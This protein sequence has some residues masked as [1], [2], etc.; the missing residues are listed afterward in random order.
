MDVP[1]DVLNNRLLSIIDAD[2]PKGL[3]F[4]KMGLVIYFYELSEIPGNKKYKN[5]ADSLLTDLIDKG[6]SIEDGLGIE[7]G[8]CGIGLGMDYLA[9]KKFISGD[10][11]FM[12]SDIDSSLFRHI[13]FPTLGKQDDVKDLS[14][15]LLYVC[16]RLRCQ[17]SSENRFLYGELAIKLVNLVADGICPSVFEEPYSYS[18]LSYRVPFLVKAISQFSSF[19]GYEIRMVKILE[20]FAHHLFGHLPSLHSH[21]LFL[22][23]SV[24]PLSSLSEDWE[25]YV[26]SL[27]D[28]IDFK[29]IIDEEMKDRN[30]FLTNGLASIFMLYD[31]IKSQNPSLSLDFDVPCLYDRM[32]NSN[33]WD[34]LLGTDHFFRIHKGLVTG[35]PGVV[36]VL[37]KI[38]SKCL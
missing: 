36:L 4:G 16:R 23:W 24:L 28:S 1:L 17:K 11:D 18:P 12:L 15:Y 20:K 10:T 26:N 13:S 3:A 25:K 37:N 2:F 19:G 30:I 14:L 6:F 8:L 27:S 35:F 34:T 9:T 29:V 5:I 33:A 38:K 7:D 31:S 21:R 32:I 22:L